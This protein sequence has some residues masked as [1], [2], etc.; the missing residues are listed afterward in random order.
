MESETI[1]TLYLVFICL[2]ILL[3]PIV[4]IV[5]HRFLNKQVRKG[6]IDLQ[7]LEEDLEN[8]RRRRFLRETYY[9]LKYGAVPGSLFYIFLGIY[10][11]DYYFCLLFIPWV[12]ICKISTKIIEHFCDIDAYKLALKEKAPAGN[13]RLVKIMRIIILV[14][15]FLCILRIIWRLFTK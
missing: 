15:L 1:I 3:L 2:I 4:Y 13:I 11:R 5:V 7:E 6:N 10:I 12:I 9:P 14:V 8:Q